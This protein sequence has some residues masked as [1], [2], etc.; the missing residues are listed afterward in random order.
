MNLWITT[1]T[2]FGHRKMEE[3]CGRPKGF[4]IRIYKHLVEVL[5]LETVLLHL[6]DVCI[7][8]DE[9]YHAQFIQS[10][11]GKHWLLRGNHDKK[12][13]NW[14]LNHGWDFVGEEILLRFNNKNI[15]FSHYPIPKQSRVDY[16]IHGHIHTHLDRLLKGNYVVEG[17][18][19]RNKDWL[20]TYDQTYHK[21]LAIE[22]TN[23]K[24]VNLEQL[25]TQYK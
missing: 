4:E 16:N 6:G 5:T 14:Y 7:G 3:Y 17:E 23:Y 18:K 8:K 25:L 22:E 12:T 9:A 21:L 13:N 10:L 15:L 11:P 2:H 1:D 19:E 24:P 20:P